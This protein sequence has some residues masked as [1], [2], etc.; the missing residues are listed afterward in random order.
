MSSSEEFKLVVLGGGTVGKSALVLRY[1]CDEFLEEHDATIED[2]YRKEVSLGDNANEVVILDILDTAGQEEYRQMMDG[3]VRNGD[4]FLLVYDI[5][6]KRSLE[7]IGPFHKNV[8]R[9]KTATQKKV[10]VPIVL[11]GNKY[12]LTDKREVPF[13]DGKKLADEFGCLFMET[14]AKNS[15]NVDEAFISLARL[16]RDSKK[17]K[18]RRSFCILL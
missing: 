16:I 10:Q 15:T 8:I 17:P 13:A 14:S 3:W 12:D 2:T 6:N 4:G 1:V 9:G 7:E 5:S 18:K 11:V